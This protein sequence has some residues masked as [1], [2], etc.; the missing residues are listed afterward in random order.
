MALTSNAKESA[1][2]SLVVCCSHAPCR[3]RKRKDN[4]NDR[5]YGH[6]SDDASQALQ[7]AQLAVSKDR[8]LGNLPPQLEVHNRVQ[9]D[10]AKFRQENPDVVRPQTNTLVFHVDPA[11]RTGR[12]VNIRAVHRQRNND[13]D[14]N[15]HPDTTDKGDEEPV[16]HFVSPNDQQESV[17]GNGENE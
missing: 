16:G 5:I 11:P 12:N 1:A 7:A 3:K 13:D 9:A 15:K 4:V 17:E 2:G 10:S 14:G 8:G 6:V